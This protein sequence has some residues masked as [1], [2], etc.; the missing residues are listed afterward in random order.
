MQNGGGQSTPPLGTS[1]PS[2]L[3]S[4]GDDRLPADEQRGQ[5]GADKARHEQPLGDARG[6]HETARAQVDANPSLVGAGTAIVGEQ[7]LRT[8]VDAVAPV[9]EAECDLLC[10]VSVRD[11]HGRSRYVGPGR[12]TLPLTEITRLKGLTHKV[13]R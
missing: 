2:Y 1:D 10:S 7:Q 13:V 11:V 8:M 12:V 6:P 3:K 9:A 4:Q 5:T